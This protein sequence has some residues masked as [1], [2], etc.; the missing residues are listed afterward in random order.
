MEL[1]FN[2][3]PATE[4]ILVE[5]YHVFDNKDIQIIRDLILENKLHYTDLLDLTWEHTLKTIWSDEGHLQTRR[6]ALLIIR[7][8]SGG[9]INVTG[10]RT[11][12][13][14]LKLVVRLGVLEYAIHLFSMGARVQADYKRRPQTF[15]QSV[16]K[17]AERGSDCS[18][19]VDMM[20]KSGALADELDICKGYD[21]FKIAILAGIHKDGIDLEL[22]RLIL[23]A[24]VDVNARPLCRPE[25]MFV[26]WARYHGAGLTDG[27]S[28]L[29]ILIHTYSMLP[30]KAIELSRVDAMAP[31]VEYLGCSWCKHQCISKRNRKWDAT[32]ACNFWQESCNRT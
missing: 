13:C 23:D 19:L 14:V 7:D 30:G 10:P 29:Q 3:I 6:E 12:R 22:A 18:K 31:M 28:P 27:H 20:L 17:Q 2:P 4:R 26:W 1:F 11:Q 15:V 9:N 8:S 5:A 32:A 21:E 24:G 16:A 25:K